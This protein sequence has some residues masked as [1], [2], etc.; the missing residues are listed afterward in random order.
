MRV[1][2]KYILNSKQ[3]HQVMD[4]LSSSL[5]SDQF[6]QES[7]YDV[8]SVYYDTQDFDYY[9][10]K[11]EGEYQHR[12]ARLRTY[13]KK[14]FLGDTYFEIKYKYNENSYKKRTKLFSYSCQK[15]S[16]SAKNNQN[17]L[18]LNFANNQNLVKKSNKSNGEDYNLK[19]LLTSMSSLGYE[20][21]MA[22]LVNMQILGAKPIFPV[23]HV[24]YKR[25]AYYL[26]MGAIKIRVNV[27][28]QIVASTEYKKTHDYEDFIF[29]DGGG[30][31]EIKAPTR[32]YYSELGELLEIVSGARSTFSKYV[33]A[34]N[35]VY[36]QLL[37][38]DRI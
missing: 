8:S 27:D 20:L 5:T 34:V 14:P 1:E 32:S 19:L 36:P 24:L 26:M 31:L 13:A 37:Y 10:E 17:T 3:I 23:C 18:K 25:K 2:Y 28:F 15:N 7:G 38:G 21:Q 29:P 22:D 11:L 33:S 12:K 4:L 35:V 30:V 16:K 9:F 6:S